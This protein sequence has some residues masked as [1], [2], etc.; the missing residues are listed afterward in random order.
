MIRTVSGLGSLFG[1]RSSFNAWEAVVVDEAVADVKAANGRAAPATD[2]AV[3]GVIE[4]GGAERTLRSAIDGATVGVVVV[5][6]GVIDA[7]VG[8][9]AVTLI[10]NGMVAGVAAA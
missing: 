4:G 5:V 9:A 3:V 8:V 1:N 6:V 10:V 7:A 2:A